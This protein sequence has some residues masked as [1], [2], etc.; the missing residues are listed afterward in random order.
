VA[1]FGHVA[2]HVAETTED[3]TTVAL[4]IG[5]A[6]NASKTK[7]IIQRN[8]KDNAPETIE[9]NKEIQKHRNF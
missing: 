8:K 6:I 1:V 2:K 7:I 5:L 4:W 9:R 3:M